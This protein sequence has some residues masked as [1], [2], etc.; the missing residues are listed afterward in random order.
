MFSEAECAPALMRRIH[1][2]KQGRAGPPWSG[3]A[4]MSLPYPS[5]PADV[6]RPP[7]RC[8]PARQAWAAVASLAMCVTLL[9]AAEFMPVS[10]LSPIATDLHATNGMAG[11]AISISGLFA[12]AASLLVGTVAGRFDRR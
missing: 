2:P 12:V 9:I 8:R 1:R 11:Q 3:R 4:T 5:R 7:C 10:L 6:Y